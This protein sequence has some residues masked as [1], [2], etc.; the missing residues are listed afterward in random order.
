MF[1]LFK[2]WCLNSYR[3]N[4]LAEMALPLTAQCIRNKIR[5][6]ELALPEWSTFLN[7]DFDDFQL[8]AAGN[9]IIMRR[10]SF[11]VQEVHRLVKREGILI[12]SS[13]KLSQPVSTLRNIFSSVEERALLDTARWKNGI[14]KQEKKFL[15]KEKLKKIKK[16]EFEKAG[17]GPKFSGLTIIFLSVAIGQR[18]RNYSS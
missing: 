5:G 1:K 6:Q 8:T 11:C 9:K 7:Q 3:P 12:K 14:R 10:V 16:L 2:E 18:P 4:S 15:Q 17:K 13:I